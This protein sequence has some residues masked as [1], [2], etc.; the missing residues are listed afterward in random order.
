[1]TSE[2]REFIPVTTL[3]ADRVDYA[4]YI[5]TMQSEENT[6]QLNGH[7]GDITAHFSC[8][9]ILGHDCLC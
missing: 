1:M 4:S 6:L 8:L 3:T 2:V 9:C 5:T 7:D